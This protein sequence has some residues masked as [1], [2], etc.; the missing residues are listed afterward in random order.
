MGKFAIHTLNGGGGAV[1][2]SPLPGR[3][4]AYGDDLET[5]LGWAPDMVLSMTEASEMARFGAAGLGADLA[6]AGVVWHHLPLPD[7]GAPPDAGLKNWPEIS[8]YAHTILAQGGRVLVHCAG[9]CG[10]SGMIALRLLVEAGE[11]PKPALVRLRAVRPCAVETEAQ[12]IW[13]VAGLINALIN[14]SS[15]AR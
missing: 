1:A 5:L 10:R 12:R 7:F 6:Q 15:V 14:R 4:G 9:G 11:A 2:L 13:A 8:N 3:Y